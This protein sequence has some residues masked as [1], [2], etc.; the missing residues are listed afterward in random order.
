MKLLEA[1]LLSVLLRLAFKH[2]EVV[3]LGDAHRF[4]DAF[5]FSEVV[6]DLLASLLTERIWSIEEATVEVIKFR[7]AVAECFKV[8][9]D[10]QRTVEGNEECCVARDEREEEVGAIGSLTDGLRDDRYEERHW[11][12]PGQRIYVES[13][14]PF[15][16][17]FPEDQRASYAA[18]ILLEAL[19]IL[20]VKM[21]GLRET[22][23]TVVELDLAKHGAKDRNKGHGRNTEIADACD[24]PV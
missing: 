23:S 3:G 15:S 11:D 7:L 1:R 17:V 12:R 22:T 5:D 8:V 13:L 2:R 6:V 16:L 21:R 19:R 18:E 4:A 14:V 9:L 24:V 20:I 10:L